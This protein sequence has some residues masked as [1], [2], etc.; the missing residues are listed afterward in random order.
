MADSPPI[1]L[2]CNDMLS[3]AARGV[4][5][6]ITIFAL[7]AAAAAA[8]PAR[9]VPPAIAWHCV[10]EF[11]EAFHVLCVPRA[12]EPDDARAVAVPVSLPATGPAPSA[13]MR[14]VAQRG[15]A[16]V[17]SAPAWRVPLHLAPTDRR[18]V[19][20]L[21]TSVLCGTRP[22]CSADYENRKLRVAAR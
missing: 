1:S 13:D 14:P 12:V 8:E 18:L 5:Q 16:E 3:R 21:L 6:T 10:Q 19:D 15:D 11:D 22:A 7:P 9:S 17:F 2:E 4:V 20:Q